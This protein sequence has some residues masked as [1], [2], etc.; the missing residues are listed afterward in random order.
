LPTEALQ[1]WLKRP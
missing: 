1:C